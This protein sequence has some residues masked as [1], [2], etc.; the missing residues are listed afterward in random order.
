MKWENLCIPLSRQQ[1]LYQ[2]YAPRIVFPTL[3]YNLALQWEWGIAMTQTKSLPTWSWDF[4]FYIQAG[5]FLSKGAKGLGR[6]QKIGQNH[7]ACGLLRMRRRQGQMAVQLW[8]ALLSG[9][10]LPLLPSIH[11]PRFQP[12]CPVLPVKVKEWSHL[13]PIYSKWLHFLNSF[14]D[15]LAHQIH[16]TPRWISGLGAC[17]C[18]RWINGFPERAHR[19]RPRPW[20]PDFLVWSFLHSIPVSLLVI[21]P[22]GNTVKL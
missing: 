12:N 7:K 1:A 20:T 6:S 4:L 3:C 17:S 16:T 15:S 11:R 9:P 5:P 8:R 10:R 19:V 18:H 22:S 13:S 21:Y 14:E 2:C